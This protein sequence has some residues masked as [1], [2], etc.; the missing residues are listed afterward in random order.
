MRPCGCGWLRL[1]NANTQPRTKHRIEM[2]SKKGKRK[3]TYSKEYVVSTRSPASESITVFLKNARREDDSSLFDKAKVS[4]Q[5]AARGEHTSA[6]MY[7]QSTT[8]LPS[9]SSPRSSSR[10]SSTSSF[11]S[12]SSS[13]PPVQQTPQTT[14]GRNSRDQRSKRPRLEA[15]PEESRCVSSSA[16]FF[17]LRSGSAINTAAPIV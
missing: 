6:V 3:A 11:T 12:S 4:A 9:T 5:A 8:P 16:T 1:A 17:S 15:S 13:V 10:S 7:T 2:P 14:Y